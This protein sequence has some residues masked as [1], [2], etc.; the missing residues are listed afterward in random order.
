MTMSFKFIAKINKYIKI[1]RNKRTSLKSS[2]DGSTY[3]S[4]EFDDEIHKH[5]RF[6]YMF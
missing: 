4:W 1:Q 6:I 2:V 5:P 3:Y